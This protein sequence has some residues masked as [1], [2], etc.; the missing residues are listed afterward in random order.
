MC[1][2]FFVFCILGSAFYILAAYQNALAIAHEGLFTHE[3]HRGAARR[4]N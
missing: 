1:W 4:G 3:A 2:V